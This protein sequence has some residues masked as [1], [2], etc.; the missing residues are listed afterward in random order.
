MKL[1]AGLVLVGVMWSCNALAVAPVTADRALQANTPH[2]TAPEIRAA[3]PQKQKTKPADKVEQ[4]VQES[5]KATTP[6]VTEESVQLKGV[7]G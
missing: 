7:R 6:A 3:K 5:P 2:A 1:V 4:K